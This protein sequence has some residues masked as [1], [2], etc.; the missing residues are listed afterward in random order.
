MRGPEWTRD[1]PDFTEDEIEAI[2]VPVHYLGGMV[3][4]IKWFE[5]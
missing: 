2:G 3:E 1:G 5:R 4:R